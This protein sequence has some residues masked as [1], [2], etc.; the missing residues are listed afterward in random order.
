MHIQLSAVTGVGGTTEALIFGTDG[1]LRFA[2]GKL[3]GAKRGETELAAYQVDLRYDSKHVKIVGIEGGQ[4]EPVDAFNEA[5]HYDRAGLE[6][7]RIILGA[8]AAKNTNTPAGKTR[9]AVL[10]LYI[11]KGGDAE[12]TANVMAAAAPDGQKVTST[13]TI[14]SQ[15]TPEE[16]AKP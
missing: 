10:H 12:I 4:T 7:G 8:F 15:E 6:G 13:V 1:T 16:D 14:E 5:P 11:E 2:G 9:V 3:Y